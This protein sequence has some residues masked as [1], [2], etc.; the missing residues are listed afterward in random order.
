ME[1]GER[2]LDLLAAHP[3]TAR[4]I[5]RKLAQRFVMDAP[6][7]ALVDRVAQEFLRTGGDLTATY[8]ALF[9]SSEFWSEA[10]RGSKVKTPLEFTVSAVRSLGGETAGDQ[11]MV[12]ALARMGQPLYRAQPPTGWPEVAQP[13][14]NPGALVSRI[15]FGLRLASGRLTGTHVPLPAVDGPPE[16]VVDRVATAVLHGPVSPGTRAT[17]MAALEVGPDNAMADGERRRVDP[18]RLVGL[19]LGSP[20]FQKQ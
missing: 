18:A 20:E 17:L 15:D 10:A 5:A 2:V 7:P 6:P 13:W 16:A 11:P 4:F 9:T 1:D 14:V 8:R 19:V 3:S 12:Q